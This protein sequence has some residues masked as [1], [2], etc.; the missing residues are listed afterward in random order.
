MARR[1]SRSTFPRDPII[2]Q[3][4]HY[5]DEHRISQAGLSQ[6]LGWSAVVLG[7]YERGDRNVTVGRLR[8]WCDALG[9]QLVALGP[10]NSGDQHTWLEYAVAYRRGDVTGHAYIECGTVEEALVVAEAIPHSTVVS[11]RHTTTDW[12]PA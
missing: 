3:L 10:A 9:H 12:E 7:S 4:A 1:P 2:N 6:K 8:L 11:R 5:R